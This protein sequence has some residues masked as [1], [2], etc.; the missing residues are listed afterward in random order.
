MHG[1][2][3]SRFSV[4]LVHSN[5]EVVTQ[6][7]PGAAAESTSRLFRLN[8]AHPVRPDP[9]RTDQQSPV[10]HEPPVLGTVLRDNHRSGG[11][12]LDLGRTLR[13][14]Q[15]RQLRKS[16]STAYHQLRSD[17]DRTTRPVTLKKENFTMT[18]SLLRS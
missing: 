16:T 3:G 9:S 2:T 1:I 11:A 15:H 12:R 4:K 18:L 5:I 7:G 17:K 8:V 14:I 10:L 6:I 13:S